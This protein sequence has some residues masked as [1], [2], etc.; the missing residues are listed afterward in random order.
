MKRFIQI[1]IILILGVSVNSCCDNVHPY[2]FRKD[3]LFTKGERLENGNTHY[4]LVFY[5]YGKDMDV[6][7][8]EYEK[9]KNFD[10]VYMVKKYNHWDIISKEYYY[11]MYDSINNNKI[12][13]DNKLLSTDNKDKKYYETKSY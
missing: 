6:T 7:Y 8:G 4:T 2:V 1:I 9:I 10:T 5:G 12:N 11:Q 3:V 13:K